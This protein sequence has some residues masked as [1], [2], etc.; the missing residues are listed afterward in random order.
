MAK[1]CVANIGGSRFIDPN[2]LRKGLNIGVA[3][4]DLDRDGMTIS[5]ALVQGSYS[6]NAFQELKETTTAFHMMIDDKTGIVVPKRAFSDE[7]KRR[8]FESLVAERVGA[9]R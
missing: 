4:F 2:A 3:C 9:G 5:L 1:Q 6:W 7:S 8:A